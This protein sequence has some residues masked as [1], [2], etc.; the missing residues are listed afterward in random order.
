MNCRFSCRSM[1][2]IGDGLKLG[3]GVHNYFY[4]ALGGGFKYDMS[5]HVSQVAQ[6]A[7]TIDLDKEFD[8]FDVPANDNK[9]IDWRSNFDGSVVGGT[10]PDAHRFVTTVGSASPA[11]QSFFNFGT[12]ELASYSEYDTPYLTSKEGSAGVSYIGKLG[13]TRYFMSYNKPV[14]EGVDGEMKEQTSAVFATGLSLRL[15]LLLG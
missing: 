10:T 3:L 9:Q 15:T 2:S 4:D 1:A 6:N 7:K 14:E 12:N 5:G 11:I 13:D 8:A